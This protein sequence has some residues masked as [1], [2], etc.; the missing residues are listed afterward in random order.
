MRTY[1]VLLAHDVPHYGQMEIAAT[2]DVEA[3]AE[4]RAHWERVQRDRD[5]EPWPLTEA[6]HDSAVLARIVEITDETGRQVAADVRLDTYL[7]R[8]AP[9]DLSVKQIENASPMYAALIEIVRH[10]TA[11]LAA[12]EFEKHLKLERV[13]SIA[14]GVIARTI[15]GAA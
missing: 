3:L 1:T 14:H 5:E 2:G 11:G 7:L 4:A 10:A 9:T 6:Q 13:L 12:D 8:V 15:G